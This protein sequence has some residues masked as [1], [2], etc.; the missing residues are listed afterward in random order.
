MVKKRKKEE[1]ICPEC[2]NNSWVTTTK[3]AKC[4]KCGYLEGNDLFDNSK[5]NPKVIAG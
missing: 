2:G 5:S 1:H 3:G 4:D